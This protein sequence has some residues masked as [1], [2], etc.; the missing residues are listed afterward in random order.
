VNDGLVS[1]ALGG[2]SFSQDHSKTGFQMP[3][4]VAVQEPGSW[5]VRPE[6]K[7]GVSTVNGH[8]VTSGGVD[9]VGDVGVG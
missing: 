3:I 4:N 6:A 8:D 1:G 5:V 9:E 2:G 7:C